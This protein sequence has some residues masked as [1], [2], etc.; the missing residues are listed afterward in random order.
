MRLRTGVRRG[1]VSGSSSP[2]VG[3][4]TD[5]E[6]RWPFLEVAR[7]AGNQAMSGLVDRARLQRKLTINPPGDV[8]EQEADYVADSVMRMP[9]PGARSELSEGAPGLQRCA[10]GGACS[11]CRT[12]GSEEEQEGQPLHRKASESGA[13]ATAP[14]VVHE[15]LR[16]S[17]EPLDTATR[18][19]MEPRLGADLGG[20]RVHRDALAA[21]SARAVSALAYTV[22]NHVVFGA[23]RYSPGTTE[24]RRLLAHELAH[25]FQQGFMPA[26][27][28]KRSTT[29]PP[30][31]AGPGLLQRKLVA[32]GS[33][34]DFAAM[35]NRIIGVQ[36]EIRISATG[37]VSVAATNVV[38]P[39][40]RDALEL[41]ATIRTVI[42]DAKTTTIE[43]I[44]GATSVRATDRSVIVGN[45]ALGRVDL[46][47]VAAFGFES[48]HS[49][50]GDNAAVQLIHEITEQY[51]KQVHR[52][53]FPVAHPA[54]YAAQERLLGARLVKESPMT[55][56]G[57]GTLGEVT[58][59]YRY[60]DGREVDVIVRMDFATGAIVSVR[61]VVR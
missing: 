32:T 26:A 30:F 51:R 50:M 52:E 18:H 4:L 28:L 34:A 42:G 5:Y 53:G 38:G 17:G 8:Y 37:E 21:E 3:R 6:V 58:T 45:Y 44:H 29:R 15:V 2:A 40:T 27:S 16:H 56:V 20:V 25:V 39:P 49:R 46:D 59:T 31:E 19:F 60:P 57:G 14:P 13:P 9:D 7:R 12:G 22:G 54:G 11:S 35:V 55:P 23:G 1:W 43:F 36:N 33:T 47:D 41:L 24:G 61:R 10:C 48:S